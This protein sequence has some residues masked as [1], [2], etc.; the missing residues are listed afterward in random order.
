MSTLPKKLL[1]ITD[2]TF[3]LPDDFNGDFPDAL[4]ILTDYIN[5][6][7][8]FNNVDEENTSTVESLLSNNDTSKLCMRY[9]IFEADNEFNYKL[10]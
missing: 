10:K 8:R 2:L 4:N 6:I 1:R 9:G 3:V 7:N 5:S